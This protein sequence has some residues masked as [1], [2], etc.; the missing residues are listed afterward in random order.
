[1]ALEVDAVLNLLG[2]GR[3]H[4]AELDFAGGDGA[5]LARFTQP[6][7]EEAGELPHGVQSQASGHYRVTDEMAGEEP[8]VGLDIEFGT[9]EAF[10]EFP[11]SLAHF[12]DAVEH[13]HWRRWKLRIAGTEKFAPCTCQKLFVIVAGFL[14]RHNS[15]LT[16]HPMP[17][18]VTFSPPYHSFFPGGNRTRKYSERKH[19]ARRTL[20]TLLI[21]NS[22]RNI[23]CV[24]ERC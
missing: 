18:A 13:Q 12:R 22:R 24:V 5:A 21:G 15:L 23:S 10:A 1:D 17:R 16:S 19:A 20:Y 14:L 6:A 7:E 3:D 4:A 8:K 2:C 9:D 11:A